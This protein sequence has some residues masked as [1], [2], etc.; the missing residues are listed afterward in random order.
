MA[1]R[2]VLRTPRIDARIDAHIDY[3]QKKARRENPPGHE[4]LGEDA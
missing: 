1:A 3:G 4:V 2:L